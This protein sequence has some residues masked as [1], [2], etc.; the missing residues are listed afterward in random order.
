M[1]RW[2]QKSFVV[3]KKGSINRHSYFRKLFGIMYKC[4]GLAI[5]LLGMH[6]REMKAS[7]YQKHDVQRTFIYVSP[8]Q[9]TIYTN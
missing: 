9:E 7:V 6:P 3:L 8:K 1:H 2:Q 4:Y 5:S